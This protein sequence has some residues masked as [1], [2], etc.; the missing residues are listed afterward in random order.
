MKKNY[1]VIFILLLFNV[2][3]YS[4]VEKVE[5]DNQIKPEEGTSTIF[6]KAECEEKQSI[7]FRL[8]NNTN[9][10]IAVSTFSFYLTPDNI[11]K[12]T[13]QNGKTVYLMPNNKEISSLFYFTETEQSQGN[14]K[15]VVLGGYRTDSYNTSWIGSKDSI[16]FS[17]PKEELKDSTEIYIM[18]RY[19]WELNEKGI[20]SPNE[21]QH[22]AYFRFPDYNNPQKL[23]FCSKS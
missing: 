17:I 11:R 13:L 21:I 23:A 2:F 6:V 5:T 3:S 20:F 15:S 9:W 14:K 16:F 7:R 4:Q 22:R 19:E 18:F 12:T 1:A 10:A 8:F